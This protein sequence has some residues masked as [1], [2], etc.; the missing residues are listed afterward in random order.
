[1]ATDG[2]V[3]ATSE[4]EKA[5]RTLL[6]GVLKYGKQHYDP[7]THL[8]KRMDD[9]YH[10][11]LDV[12]QQSP[13][14]AAALLD[15]GTRLDRANDII[16]ALLDHQWLKDRGT[17]WYGN[18]IW[19]HDL[20]KPVDANAV[21]FMT[22]WLCYYL[23]EHEQRLTDPARTRLLKALPLCLLAV[24]A[25]RGPVHYDNIWLLKAA[26]LVMLAKTIEQ[27]KLLVEAE[28]RLDQWIAY[29][30]ANGINEF[31]SP[32]YAAVNI[33][34][35]EFIWHYAP[36]SS[37]R[38]RSRTQE[39]LDLLYADMFMNWHW[40]GSIG[41]GTHSRAY[42]RDRTSGKSLVCFLVY[43]QC[44]GKL[45]GDIRPFEYNFAVNNYRVPDRIRAYANI[46][47]ET[48]YSLRASHP[49]WGNRGVRV[50][51]SLYVAP[52]VSLG[53]QTGYRANA[54]QAIPFKITYAGSKVDER[55]SFIRPVPAH[56]TD[57]RTRGSITFAAH[58]DEGHAIVLYEADI[59]GRKRSA[60]LRLVIE[61]GAGGMLDEIR[62]NGKPYER[63]RRELRPGDTVAWRVHNS[64]VA[65]RLLDA[66][67]VRADSPATLVSRGYT[68]S[69]TKDVGLCLHGL[70]AYRPRTPVGLNNLSAGFV[71]HV[72]ATADFPSL[73]AM[74]EAAAGWDIGETH[75]DGRRD[76]RWRDGDRSWRLAW[77]GNKNRVTGRYTD[78][79]KLGQFPL[80]DSPLMHLERGDPVRVKA[81]R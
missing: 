8:V 73:A 43:K 46:E 24:R 52:A 76:I 62:V 59:K 26:S 42:P 20:K 55:A 39:L 22:P 34:A 66:W 15:A 27:P 69:P 28:R 9:M 81:N 32:C 10:G 16:H 21:A 78:G 54:D 67:G 44:G 33:Y 13:S 72:A 5:N 71:V 77:D 53:T 80:Y 70:V 38:L 3:A 75:A 45:R 11:R 23:I 35:L 41:A 49:A 18:F 29:V 2:P 30:S 56:D 12:A 4:F 25:H 50:D 47:A 6:R 7:S 57:S 37:Q 19:W 63:K 58:Q 61:P 64:L 74:E 14:Y 36:R 51:R 65:I 40:N 48:P 1:M 31:N 17:P 79:Q 68:L 60:Y